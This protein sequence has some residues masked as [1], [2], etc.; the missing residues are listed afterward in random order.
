M[1]VKYVSWVNFLNF[2]PFAYLSL[3]RAPP[4]IDKLVSW[5]NRLQTFMYSVII[6]VEKDKGDENKIA[7]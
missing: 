3:L 4:V 5:F 6:K 7:V 2:I 1:Y